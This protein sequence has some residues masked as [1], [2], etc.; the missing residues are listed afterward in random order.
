MELIGVGNFEIQVY[1]VQFLVQ[2]NMQKVKLKEPDGSEMWKL[3][4]RFNM[5]SFCFI[6][7]SM[8]QFQAKKK[9]FVSF[10][11]KSGFAG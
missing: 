10:S 8:E 11:L 6:M 7:I 3:N 2:V 5:L 4:T 9:R 1:L